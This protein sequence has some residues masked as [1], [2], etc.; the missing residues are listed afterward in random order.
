MTK[1]EMLASVEAQIRKDIPRLME[2]RVGCI[3]QNEWS[4]DFFKVY[5]ETENHIR[6]FQ[7]NSDVPNEQVINKKH[8]STYTPLVIIGHDIMLND[9]Y[10]WLFLNDNLHDIRHIFIDGTLIPKSGIIDYGLHINFDSPYLKYQSEIL[11]KFLYN[12]IK[13]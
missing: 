5:D 4:K 3:L 9:V 1:Q 11:I 13:E 6:I 10:Q 2:L 7:L 8:I 12:L